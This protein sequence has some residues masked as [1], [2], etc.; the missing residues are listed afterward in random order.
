[1]EGHLGG[2]GR[3]PSI[4]PDI[5]K[6]RDYRE[7]LA[8]VIEFRKFTQKG[9]SLRWL[10]SRC[11]FS[12]PSYIQTILARKRPLSIEA[13]TTVSNVFKHSEF[14]AEFFRLLVQS[15]NAK[16]GRDFEKTVQDLENLRKLKDV[17]EI[18]QETRLFLSRWENVALYCFLTDRQ[19]PLS[20]NCIAKRFAKRISSTELEDVLRQ[21]VY[22]GFATCV[23]VDGEKRFVCKNDSILAHRK[24]DRSD[25]NRFHQKIL[26][27][28]QKL[29]NDGNEPSLELNGTTVRVRKDRLHEMRQYVAEVR[30]Q[31]LA[32]FHDETGED[33]FHLETILLPMSQEQESA[34]AR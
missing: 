9:F 17:I 13:A 4:A 21:L 11:N 34:D 32:R 24:I 19:E 33:I 20:F 15:N 28:G 2:G 31:F 8:D 16:N 30:S 25:L 6:Y 3:V 12:S 29:L 22:L 14:E 10:N 7:Y 26:E 1:M 27:L 5:S 23:E 18:G